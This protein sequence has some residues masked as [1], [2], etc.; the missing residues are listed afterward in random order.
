MDRKTTPQ[1]D[2]W[3]LESVHGYLFIEGRDAWLGL[4]DNLHLRGATTG[5]QGDGSCGCDGQ[6]VHSLQLGRWRGE[7][8]LECD[9]CR[10]IVDNW[11][12][13]LDNIAHVAWTQVDQLVLHVSNLNLREQTYH[14]SALGIEVTSQYTL[15]HTHKHTP[16]LLLSL[17]SKK[18]PATVSNF[19]LP[20]PT[21]K[22]RAN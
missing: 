2:S 4:E 10:G 16:K 3:S 1:R 21:K 17:M 11:H 18:K 8:Q 19:S 6:H 7:S 13:L 9:G 15:T 20:R 5:I 14:E 22:K 12:V